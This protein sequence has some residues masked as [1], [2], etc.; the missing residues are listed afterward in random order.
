LDAGFYSRCLFQFL[1]KPILNDILEERIPSSGSVLWAGYRVFFT[2][3]VPQHEHIEI[4]DF[5]TGPRC[6]PEK[7]ETGFDAG[8]LLKTPNIDLLTQYLPPIGVDQFHEE[9]FEGDIVQGV[10]WLFGRHIGH[11]SSGGIASL[12]VHQHIPVPK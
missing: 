5:F 2:L 6:F 4:L 12:T 10:V 9:F 7:G 8:V 3:F 1:D 11:S